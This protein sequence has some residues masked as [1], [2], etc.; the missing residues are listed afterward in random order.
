MK[1][2][3]VVGMAARS[4]NRDSASLDIM[5]VVTR[6]CH[7]Q[8]RL[9]VLLTELLEAFTITPDQLPPFFRLGFRLGS[10]A[11]IFFIVSCKR[12]VPKRFRIRWWRNMLKPQTA[13]IVR[14][15]KTGTRGRQRGDERCS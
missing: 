11:V 1:F 15:Y 13:S 4:A 10:V 12:I 5:E 3:T 2:H 14:R 7:E 9:C 6:T 8:N